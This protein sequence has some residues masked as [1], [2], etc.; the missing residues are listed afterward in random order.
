MIRNTKK[1]R[2]LKQE[3][4]EEEDEAFEE[5]EPDEYPTLTEA[6][7]VLFPSLRSESPERTSANLGEVEREYVEEMFERLRKVRLLFKFDSIVP[8]LCARPCSV[9]SVPMI[10]M[11]ILTHFALFLVL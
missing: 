11:L 7:K 3:H 6:V 9:I 1:S 10:A 8:F 5:V 4:W 2:G